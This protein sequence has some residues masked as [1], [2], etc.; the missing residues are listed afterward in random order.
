MRKCAESKNNTNASF[1]L[2]SVDELQKARQ[3]LL[4]Y[5]PSHIKIKP[6]TEFYYGHHFDKYQW[7]GEPP[8]SIDPNSKVVLKNKINNKCE[9]YSLISLFALMKSV[10]VLDKVK[11]ILYVEPTTALSRL[12][13]DPGVIIWTTR[14]LNVKRPRLYYNQS[15][16]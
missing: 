5:L 6:I 4:K 7:Q 3:R 8:Y 13:I 2:D 12:N 15:T 14:H 11:I 9:E 10:I 1:E 16:V